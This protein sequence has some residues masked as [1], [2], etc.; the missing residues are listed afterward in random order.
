MRRATL[1]IMF[2]GAAAALALAAGPGW[3]AALRVPSVQRA[4]VARGFA[5]LQRKNDEMRAL[6]DAPVLRVVLCGTASPLPNRERAGPCAAVMAGG[7]IW[8]VDA[9]G[10]GW[11]NLMLWHFPGTRL[12]GVLLTHFH[13]DHI[14][15]LGDVNLE[16]WV[17]GRP[18][19]LPVYGGPGVAEVVSGFTAAYA[20]D[21]GYREEHHGA[22]MLPPD[23]RAM[24]AHAVAGAGGGALAEGEAAPVLE[25]D[26]L[27][28]TAIG[29]NHAPVSPAYAYRFTYRGRSLVI[30]GDTRA[31]P[32]F[33]AAARGT[34]VMVHEAQANEVVAQLHDLMA[35]RGDARMAKLLNDIQTYHTT[36]EQAGQIAD[37]AG[38]RL[39]VLTHLTPALPDALSAA[40]FG[41]DAAAAR[42]AP[43]L[44]G[45]DGLMVS[46]PPGGEIR[47]QR[48]TD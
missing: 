6:V 12:S 45:F 35:A 26:G 15:D 19:A 2:C 10:G 4:I 44:V 20:P 7:H 43:T 39:L 34:E 13:S 22:A 37:L 16:S 36:P 17:A 27:R 24:V 25:Q 3:R 18:V 48:L 8:L 41:S 33:A 42:R 40:V 1:A 30:S 9:G 31:S 38:A 14:Q 46:L 47:Q 28:I 21:T 5:R 23:A 29:V 32:A 11:R